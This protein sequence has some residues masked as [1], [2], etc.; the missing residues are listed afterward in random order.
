MKIYSI[1]ITLMLLAAIFYREQIV[2]LYSP[3]SINIS[4]EHIKRIARN[5]ISDEHI[6]EIALEAAKNVFGQFNVRTTPS[7]NLRYWSMLD[8]RKIEASLHSADYQK[9]SLLSVDKKLFTFPVQRFSSSDQEIIK[10]YLRSKQEFENFKPKK[11]ISNAS[12]K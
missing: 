6:Q 8:G 11:P 12:L 5:A 3:Q 2:S 1:F 10:Q 7:T 9:V 4:D